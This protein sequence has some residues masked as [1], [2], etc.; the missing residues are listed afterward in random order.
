[1]LE[2]RKLEIDTK[3]SISEQLCGGNSRF[4]RCLTRVH[5][6]IPLP[7]GDMVVHA[8][9][10]FCDEG[11]FSGCHKL[12]NDSKAIYYGDELFSRGHHFKILEHCFGSGKQVRTG[13]TE[14]EEVRSFNLEVFAHVQ[15]RICSAK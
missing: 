14:S 4:S 6:R 13:F 12:Y 2:L 10:L 11:H 9:L 5:R 1:M 7:N 8:D 3:V 15:S